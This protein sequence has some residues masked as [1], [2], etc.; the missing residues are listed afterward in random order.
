MPLCVVCERVSLSWRR[1]QTVEAAA[2]AV[3]NAS[4]SIFLGKRTL[5]VEL[6]KKKEVAKSL[7]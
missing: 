4:N 5:S 6:E 2:A 1:H 7:I 3:R